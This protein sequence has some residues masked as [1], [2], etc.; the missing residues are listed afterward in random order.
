[1]C[2]LGSAEPNIFDILDIYVCIITRTSVHVIFQ[3]IISV[4]H[5]IKSFH[6]WDTDYNPGIKS[7][8]NFIPCFVRCIS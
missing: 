5:C 8:I 6:A 2:S 4:M 3:P 1:M 7:G